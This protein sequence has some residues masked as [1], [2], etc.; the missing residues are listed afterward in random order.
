MPDLS[1]AVDIEVERLDNVLM[2]PRAAVTIER[3]G[4]AVD[5]RGPGRGGRQA[6]TVGSASVDSAVIAKGVDEGTIV[7]MSPAGSGR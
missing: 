2:L 5:V 4:A 3:G 7:T 6:V 1:A